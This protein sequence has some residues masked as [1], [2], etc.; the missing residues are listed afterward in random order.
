[1]NSINK[2][3]L[4]SFLLLPFFFSC[5]ADKRGRVDVATQ[6]NKGCDYYVEVVKVLDGDTFDGITKDKAELRFRIYGIDAPER[7]QPY[8]KKAAEYLSSLILGKKVG[9]KVQTKR[10]GWGRPVVW[11]YTP[12]GLDVGAELL[13]AGMAW[14]FKQYDSSKE[15]NQLENTARVEKKGL[16]K[17]KEPQAPWEFRAE[18]R[19]KR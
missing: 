17:E 9:I 4:L 16:W 2:Q 11:V 3:V 19:K 10:D 6:K 13:K 14:H 5:Q 7:T 15:Y 1:M 12:T 8:S 18:K